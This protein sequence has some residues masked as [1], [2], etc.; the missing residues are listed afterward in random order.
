[1]I[2]SIRKYK[3][4]CLKEFKI[5][6][7]EVTKMSKATNNLEKNPLKV[8]MRLIFSSLKIFKFRIYF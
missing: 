6:F 5:L 2:R 4:W 7:K 8:L 1:M 3:L